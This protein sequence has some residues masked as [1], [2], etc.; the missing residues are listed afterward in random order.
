MKGGGVGEYLKVGVKKE[1]NKGKRET[2]GVKNKIP[3]PWNIISTAM[4][5][6]ESVKKN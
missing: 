5:G 2:E 3:S 6:G 1:K 4:K